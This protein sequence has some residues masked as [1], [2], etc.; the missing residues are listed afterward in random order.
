MGAPEAGQPTPS[1]A[2][3]DAADPSV[4]LQCAQLVLPTPWE[5]S[6]FDS[7]RLKC[8]FAKSNFDLA[9][10]NLDFG[11]T[12]FGLAKSNCDLVST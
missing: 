9:K 5:W 6:K 10:S 12:K 1:D 4:C 7:A 11:K 8:S 3:S 2:R